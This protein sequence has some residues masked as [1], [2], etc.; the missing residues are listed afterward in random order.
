MLKRNLQTR[1][2]LML[3]TGIVAVMGGSAHA[4]TIAVSFIGANTGVNN[5]ADYVLPYQLSI[6]DTIINAV[7]YD[8]FDQV[9]A[10]ESWIANELTLDDAAV[11]GQFS[12]NPDARAA[13][14]QIAFLSQQTTSSAQDQ[15]DL[16]E[17]IWNVFAV[18][19]Y[20]VTNGMQNYLNLL[21]TTD[22]TTFNFDQIRFLED[23]DQTRSGRAQAFVIDPPTGVPEPNTML[24]LG[25]GCLLIVIRTL[26]QKPF[27][28][29]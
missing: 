13:Y 1:A 29:E 20:A 19:K 18:N 14:K 10:G 17:D 16:Q 26:K 25:G 21:S 11:S 4:D 6:N 28:R 15:I 22:F 3:L 23:A 9:T 8:V 27:A 7:C 2:R 24:F 5:G 12:G